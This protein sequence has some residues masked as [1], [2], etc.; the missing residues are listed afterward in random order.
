MTIFYANTTTKWPRI[1]ARRRWRN[2]LIKSSSEVAARCPNSAQSICMQQNRFHRFNYRPFASLKSHKG[3]FI[4]LINCAV[5][6]QINRKRILR[7]ELQHRLHTSKWIYKRIQVCTISLRSF[8]HVKYRTLV[9]RCSWT[10]IRVFAAK[11]K[12]LRFGSSA[13]H[14]ASLIWDWRY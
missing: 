8:V 14:Q 9:T 13:L 5:K 7:A 10:Y 1:C 2:A 11:F 6:L 3:D 12:L 4:S